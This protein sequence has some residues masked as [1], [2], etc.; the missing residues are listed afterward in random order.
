MQNSKLRKI[1]PEI[2]QF[3]LNGIFN[4]SRDFTS[5][6]SVDEQDFDHLFNFSFEIDRMRSFHQLNQDCWQSY[7]S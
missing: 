1:S 7:A 4:V 2:F 5:A 3:P 6:V